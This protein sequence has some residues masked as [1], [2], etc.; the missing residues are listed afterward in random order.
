MPLFCVE[1]RKTWR[2]K[3][4]GHLIQGVDEGIDGRTDEGRKER[5]RMDE[6]SIVYSYLFGSLVGKPHPPNKIF[7]MNV[8]IRITQFT[9][10]F[11]ILQR[12]EI[13][14]NTV[15]LQVTAHC[16]CA[17]PFNFEASD[18]VA[19]KGVFSN[20]CGKIHGSAST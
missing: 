6:R 17:L 5:S 10:M 2:V 19:Y 12:S 20:R 8:M 4:P 9:H 3:L 1:N 18:H 16:T 15:C 14:R 7:R 13:Q 11:P